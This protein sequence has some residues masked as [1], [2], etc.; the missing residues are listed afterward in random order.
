MKQSNTTGFGQTPQ[1]TSVNPLPF[2]SDTSVSST[3]TG[4]T[5]SDVEHSSLFSHSGVF[6]EFCGSQDFCLADGE[7]GKRRRTVS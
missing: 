7:L 2:L 6:F 5:L 1:Q 3:E 4:E